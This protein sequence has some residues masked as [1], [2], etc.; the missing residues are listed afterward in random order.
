MM[1]I[2]L[3]QT[4]QNKLYDFEH[5]ENIWTE[6]EILDCQKEMTEKNLLLAKRAASLGADVIVTAEAINFAGQP[7][8]YQGD[9][10]KLI[11]KTQDNILE[12]F[13]QTAKDSKAYLIAGM[14]YADGENELSNCAFLL[15]PD[16]EVKACYK[17]IHLAGDEKTYLK[18]G[19]DFTVTDTGYGKFG[20]AICWDMQFPET[21]RILAHKGADIIFCPTWGWEWIYGPARAYENGIYT[22][23]AMG[24]PYWMD[25]QDLRSP[26]QIISPDGRILSS[27]NCTGDDVVIGEVDLKAAKRCRESRLLERKPELYQELLQV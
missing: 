4:K 8:Q 20:F 3:L 23:A 12:K 15:D 17:K 25:I 2:A 24:V 11:K 21:A 27:G 5:R 1:K 26:S 13:L 16:G 10:K 18:A 19:E 9:Y 14:F 22:A 6:A 7:K